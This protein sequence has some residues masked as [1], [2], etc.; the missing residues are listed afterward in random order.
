MRDEA[1]RSEVY[2]TATEKMLELAEIRTGDRVLDVAAG[3]G[4]Q[5][6]LAARLVGPSGYVLATD[7]SSDMLNIAAEVV[8]RAGLKNVGTQVMDGEN[9]DLGADSFAAVICRLGLILFNNP[10]AG[11]RG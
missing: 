5:T 3:A 2:G 8:R 6:L 7:I 9:L 10:P 1:Q 4:D 11:K